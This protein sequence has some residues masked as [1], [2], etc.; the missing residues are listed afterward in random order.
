MASFK[1]VTEYGER[2]KKGPCVPCRRETSAL[3]EL[4]PKYDE[5]GKEIG[6][7]WVCRCCGKSKHDYRARRHGN[8]SYFD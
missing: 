5:K 1:Y 7:Q 3:Y 8:S 6:L 2:L 4:E